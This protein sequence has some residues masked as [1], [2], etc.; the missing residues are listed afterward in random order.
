MAEIS[1]QT[2]GVDRQSVEQAQAALDAAAVE[3]ASF[4]EGAQQAAPTP[5]TTSKWQQLRHGS[6]S[7]TRMSIA[8]SPPSPP[9]T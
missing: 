3:L 7:T 9:R 5:T 8:F 4:E 6:S 2:A 1:K